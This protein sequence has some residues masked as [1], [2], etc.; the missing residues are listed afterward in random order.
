[1]QKS[2]AWLLALVIAPFILTGCQLI[3]EEDTLPTRPILHSYRE[4]GYTMA[5]VMRGDLIATV[6]VRCRYVHAKEEHLSFSVGGAYISKVYVTEGQQVKAGQL[7]AELEQDNLQ[8][9]IASLEYQMRLLEQQ[10]VHH[11]EDRQLDVKKID[12][13][14]EDLRQR[15]EQA[16]EPVRQQ[17]LAQIEQQEGKRQDVMDSYA[18]KLQSAEDSIYLLGLRLEEAKETLKSRQIIAGMDGTVTFIDEVKEGTRSVKGQTFISI[19]DLSTTVFTVTGDNT[20]YFAPGEDVVLTCQDKELAA[21]VADPSEFDVGDKPVV[22][23]KLKQPEPTLQEGDSGTILLTLDQRLD[24]LYV[25]EDAVKTADGETFV[26]ILDENGLRTTK[27]V[28]TGLTVKDFT[29]IIEGLSEGDTVI[30]D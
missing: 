25:D 19:S 2:I 5:A 14:L 23:L 18:Q 3:P 28:T 1:M 7:L 26:F 17:L 11:L 10:K 13:M 22:Y 20:K 16:E 12:I 4:D 30:V 9:N 15:L 6:S 29:E 27:T 24:V 8:E 21:Y